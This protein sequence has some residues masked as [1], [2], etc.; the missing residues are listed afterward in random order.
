MYPSWADV[1][2]VIMRTVYFNISQH[3]HISKT[4]IGN[5][6]PGSVY[7]CSCHTS[8]SS[9]SFLPQDSGFP[10]GSTLLLPLFCTTRASAHSPHHTER[11]ADSTH[12]HTHKETTQGKETKQERENHEGEINMGDEKLNAQIGSLTKKKQKKLKMIWIGTEKS[13]SSWRLTSLFFLVPFYF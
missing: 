11:R 4:S 12:S 2:A 10:S 1:L 8:H 3:G 9:R 5:L 6:T 7:K 13:E